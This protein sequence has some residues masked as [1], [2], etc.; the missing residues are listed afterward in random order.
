MRHSSALV[1]GTTSGL[2]HAAAKLLA[3]EGCRQ[4][5]VTGRSLARVQETALQLAAETKTEV[6][7]PLVRISL[8]RDQA[9]RGIVI[10]RF[11]H[12]DHPFRA[13]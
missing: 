1:T 2:G 8:H 13:S 7:T 6:F 5:I 12:R 11:A 3:A 10:A 4:V 9:F